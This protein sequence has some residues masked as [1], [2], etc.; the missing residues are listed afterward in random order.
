M[1]NILTSIE[2]T[3]SLNCLDISGISLTCSLYNGSSLTKLAR[4]ELKSS[5]NELI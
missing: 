3:L 1:L 5:T 4:P 2:S